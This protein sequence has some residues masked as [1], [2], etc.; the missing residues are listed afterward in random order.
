[1][2]GTDDAIGRRHPVHWDPVEKGNRSSIIFV[3]I[4]VKD[5]RPLL[6]TPDCHRVLLKWWNQADRW[7]VG[8]YIIMPDHVHLFCAPSADV[9]LSAWI[10]YWKRGVARDQSPRAGESFWQRHF[11]DVQMRTSRQYESKWDYIQH[12]PVRHGLVA[13]PEEWP[14]RGERN[15]LDWHDA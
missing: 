11:W 6:A 14:F 10:T 2:S 5:R 8:K 7:V 12:N 9:S 15:V 13:Q 3:T 4:C 1:M